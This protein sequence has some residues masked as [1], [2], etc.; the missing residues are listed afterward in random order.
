[1]TWKAISIHQPHA[2]LIAMG[3]Q[4]FIVRAYKTDFRGWVMIHASKHFRDPE[5]CSREPYLGVIQA[6]GLPT[7]A[8][9]AVARITECWTADFITEKCKDDPELFCEWKPNYWGWKVEDVTAFDPIHAVGRQGLWT[10]FTVTE[11]LVELQFC[12]GQS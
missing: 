4:H 6:E 3:R 2:S 7:S 5:K 11:A 12:G 1:M 10:P 9:I 8:V